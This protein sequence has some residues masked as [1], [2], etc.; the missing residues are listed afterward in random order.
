MRQAY[1]YTITLPHDAEKVYVGSSVNVESRK[2]DHNRLLT[3][4]K[5]HSKKLQHSFKKHKHKEV[6]LVVIEECT[7]DNRDEREQYWINHHNSMECGYNMVPVDTG[8][9]ST[10]ETRML[11]RVN[12]IEKYKELEDKLLAMF[13]KYEG[14]SANAMCSGSGYEYEGFCRFSIIHKLGKR[15]DEEVVETALNNLHSFE[16]MIE[17]WLSMECG[18]VELQFQEDNPRFKREKKGYVYQEGSYDNAYFAPYR[19]FEKELQ[20]YHSGYKVVN[21]V[22]LRCLEGHEKKSLFGPLMA[23]MYKSGFEMTSI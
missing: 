23:K 17:H 5:H 12:K 16:K 1:I 6:E 20:K 10:P 9:A 14:T 13:L 2:K 11:R 18:Y 21:N 4:G 8:S 15:S 7:Q 3:N 22:L 19:Y